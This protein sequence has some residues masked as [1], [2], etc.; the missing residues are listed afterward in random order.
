MAMTNDQLLEELIEAIETG[1][2]VALVTVVKATGN[3]TK[4]L[5]KRVL[6][7][8][9][10]PPSSD[11]ALGDIGSRVIAD[12]RQCLSMRKPQMLK[13]K[14]HDGSLEIF[15]EVQRRSPTFIIVGAG[16]VALPLAQLGKMIDFEVV[17]LDDRPRFANK[18]RF[19]MADR[20]LAQPLRET[21]RNWPIDNDTYIVLVTRGHSHD[22]ECLLEVIDSPARYIGMIGSKRRVKAVFE[23]LE[24]EQHIDPAKLDRVYAP[25][26]LDIGAE[27]PIEIAIGVIAEIIN[28]YRGGRAISLSDALRADRRLPLHPARTETGITNRK[29]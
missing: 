5:G 4:A 18:Q 2:S 23:L 19:P 22:V 9:D 20:V 17:V 24:R 14:Q 3:Y 27:T 8:M 15:V 26:G 16:H 1:Q 12:A 21:L 28:V 29:S 11:L 25:I 10:T 6:V 7:W 13:Y